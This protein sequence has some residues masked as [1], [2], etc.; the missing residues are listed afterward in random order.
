MIKIKGIELGKSPKIAGVITG[1]VTQA[2]LRRAKKDGADLLE[3]RVDTFKDRSEATLSKAFKRAAATGLPILL[4]IRSKR[5]G[6]RFT[7]SDEERKKLFLQLIPLSD[8]VDIELSSVKLLKTV[9]DTAGK[10][11]KKVIVSYHNFKE[12]PTRK[13][14]E[15]VTAKARKAGAQ[16]V[17]IATMARSQKDLKVLASVLSTE[18][19]MIVIAM[20]RYGVASRVLF[21]FLGSLLSYG[22]IAGKA[23]TAPGQLQLGSLSY[24][25]KL[26]GR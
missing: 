2:A 19:D 13:K 18:K 10:K 8:A 11:R 21:P 20:G 6:A 12:T 25:M 14:L 16:C 5:E 7:V 1:T 4:T 9:V 22:A 3:I 23:S 17:K 15:A 26:F 24:A